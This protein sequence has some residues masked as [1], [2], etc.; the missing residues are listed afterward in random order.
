M[1]NWLHQFHDWRASEKDEA[2][3]CSLFLA[4]DVERL[5]RFLEKRP[6]VGSKKW[7][8]VWSSVL[9]G[10]RPENDV[11]QERMFD[12]FRRHSALTRCVKAKTLGWAVESVDFYKFS[13]LV[14]EWSWSEELLSSALLDAIQMSAKEVYGNFRHV[15]SEQRFQFAE[16]AV[17]LLKERGADLHYPIPRGDWR[18]QRHAST[19]VWNCFSSQLRHSIH[20]DMVRLL[21][22]WN[23][24]NQLKTAFSPSF[25][26]PSERPAL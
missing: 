9:I 14:K 3:L 13:T 7:A 15:S 10:R 6:R 12:L 20:P 22:S 1:K 4:Q 16:K 5:S 19:T 18:N 8:E 2:V 24:H 17:L 26:K 25:V 11:R 23:E 21:E